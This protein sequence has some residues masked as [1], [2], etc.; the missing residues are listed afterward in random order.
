MKK[1]P[2]K[3]RAPRVPFGR[4]QERERLIDT[5]LDALARFGALEQLEGPLATIRRDLD[6]E[7][8]QKSL[9]LLL[10]LLRPVVGVM[11]QRCGKLDLGRGMARPR[12][13]DPHQKR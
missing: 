4:V 1:Q 8:E 10:L 9:S 13:S 6:R 3:L 12:H 5:E 11:C 7:L 2:E